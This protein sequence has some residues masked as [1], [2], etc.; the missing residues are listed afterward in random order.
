MGQAEP[1]PSLISR[2]VARL[3]ANP[4]LPIGDALTAL[5]DLTDEA[6]Q[7][8]ALDA[9]SWTTLH[10]LGCT[11]WADLAARSTAD[12]L[13]APGAGQLTVSRL[14][15]A[16]EARNNQPARSPATASTRDSLGILQL[17]AIVADLAAWAVDARDAKRLG[18]ILSLSNRLGWVP[19]EIEE[20]FAA[21]TDCRLDAFVTVGEL[22]LSPDLLGE[23]LQTLGTGANILVRRS[24]AFSTRPTLQQLGDDLGVSRERARQI[25]TA[26]VDRALKLLASPQF[27]LL[28]W[29]SSELARLIG[30]AVPSQSEVFA[31]SIQRACR[32]FNNPDGCTAAE[33]MLWL[34]GPYELDQSGWFVRTRLSMKDLISDFHA[35]IGEDWLLTRTTA[36]AVLVD[37]GLS[38]TVVD[39]FIS[40]ARRWRQIAD[41]LWVRWD[42][43]VAAKADIVLRLT[44]CPQTAE[45]INAAIG[46]NHSTTTVRNALAADPRFVRLDKAGRFGLADW[47]L[48]E[49][50]GIA[51]EIIERIER[52]GGSVSV[53][54]LVSEFVDRF[55]VSETSVRMYAT[56]PAFV[57]TGGLVRR[58][59]AGEAYV[60]DQRIE[61]VRGA[62]LRPDGSVLLQVPV[63]REV[64]RGSGRQ[65][66]EPVAAA[67][68]IRPGARR[69]FGAPNGGR[70]LLTWPETSVTGPSLGSVR[71]LAADLHLELGDRMIL[72]F[73]GVTGSVKAQRVGKG[74]LASLTGLSLEEGKEIDQIAAAIGVRSMDVRPALQARGDHEVI[75]A[76]PRPSLTDDLGAVIDEFGNLLG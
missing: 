65:L 68:G 42:G 54:E 34:A 67:L 66:P 4:S 10:R 39:A 18:D 19:P 58:R 53:D 30:P 21:L 35:H 23:F 49:Y 29:R 5:H 75:A 32:G 63:D 8:A 76:L 22:A 26:T 44:L 51:Q 41:D 31:D 36:T 3:L 37:A 74:S 33:L 7:S 40:A 25:E 1:E 50:G 56:S 72:V 6:I 70:V 52:Q 17:Y 38:P 59:G 69:E 15:V 13:A 20:R 73:D 48:E 16:A 71:N 24:L 64:L 9:R 61:R 12:I 57:L 46:D 27:R 28:R 11:T 43:P 47:G 60:P 2:E 55:G 14:L 45:E 62:Y